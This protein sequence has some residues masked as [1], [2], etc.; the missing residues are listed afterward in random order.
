MRNKIPQKNPLLEEIKENYTQVF[1]AVKG[2][3]TIIEEMANAEMSEDEIGYITIHFASFIEK[4]KHTGELRPNVLIVCNSGIGTSNLLSARLASMYE[5]N[6]IA[7]VAFHEYEQVIAEN[8]IDYI[9]STIDLAHDSLRVIKV[10]PLIGNK[11]ISTLDQIF[12]ASTTIS[13]T[14][15]GYWLLSSAIVL[16]AMSNSYMQKCTWNSLK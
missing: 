6:I 16:S 13:S 15:K 14:S 1:N 9:I 8:N 11:D 2:N 4:Q 3:I 12:S 10:N 7:T 5:V